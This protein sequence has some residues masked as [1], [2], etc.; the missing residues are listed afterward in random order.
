MF[1]VMSR[2]RLVGIWFATLAVVIV[3]TVAAGVN[4]T[5]STIAFL[6]TLSVVPPAILLVLWRAAP[7]QTVAEILHTANSPDEGRS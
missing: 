5:A 3:S 7:P 4:M 6:L 2:N 1:K